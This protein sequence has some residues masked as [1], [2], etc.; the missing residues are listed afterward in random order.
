[1][2]RP[3]PT[4]YGNCESWDFIV[5][6]KPALNSPKIGKLLTLTTGSESLGHKVFYNFILIDTRQAPPQLSRSSTKR[7][8]LWHQKIA[9]MLLHSNQAH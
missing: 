5:G 4:I 3:E 1:M 9:E 2:T 8:K 6:K 7:L